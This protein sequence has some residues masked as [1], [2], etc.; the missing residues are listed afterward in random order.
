MSRVS[1]HYL[2]LAATALSVAAYAGFWLVRSPAPRILAVTP[3][4]AVPLAPTPVRPSPAEAIRVSVSPAPS[5]SKEVRS[6]AEL[7]ELRLRDPESARQLARRYN[8]EA[9]D[10]ADAP[11]RA[12]LIVRT[13]DD[14]RRFHEA[15]DEALAMRQRYPGSSWTNDVERH[16]LVYPLDQP[17]R[18]EQQAGLPAS[19]I[20]PQ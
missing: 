5:A 1:V 3:S 11:E 10:S 15:R 13:L 14:Q 20:V 19:E 18:E 8:A 9:P 6:M 16:V 4:T 2:A 12:W 7:R 17:S